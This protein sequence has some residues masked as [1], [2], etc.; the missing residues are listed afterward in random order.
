MGANKRLIAVAA[1]AS[2]SVGASGC[3]AL[4]GLLDLDAPTET[5][6]EAVVCNDTVDPD[7]A[8]DRDVI[9]IEDE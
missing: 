3:T 1:A 9:V 6:N 4:V 5:N 8:P 7:C 2:L